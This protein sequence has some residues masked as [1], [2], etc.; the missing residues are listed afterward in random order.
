MTGDGQ[1]SRHSEDATEVREAYS[2]LEA[3]MEALIEESHRH[4][5]QPETVQLLISEMESARRAY[6][7]AC[8]HLGWAL[9]HPYT[10]ENM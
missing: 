2:R 9:P 10:P 5:F 6:H 7:S 4:V 3:A 1:V 8:L